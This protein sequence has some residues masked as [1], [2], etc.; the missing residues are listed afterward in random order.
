[1]EGPPKD[2]EGAEPPAVAPAAAAA[3]ESAAAVIDVVEV[4]EAIFICSSAAER[5]PAADVG[6]RCSARIQ[7]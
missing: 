3:T 4:R 6:G 1:M 5:S 7:M 2:E